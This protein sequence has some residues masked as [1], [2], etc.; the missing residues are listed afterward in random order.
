MS[1]FYNDQMV[2]RREAKQQGD[3]FMAEVIDGTGKVLAYVPGDTKEEADE[4]ATSTMRG[5]N[6]Q[7]G[8]SILW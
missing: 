8:F 3:K 5:L 7:R 2:Y 4:L 6:R 1:T